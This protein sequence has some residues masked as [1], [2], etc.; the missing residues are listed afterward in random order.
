MPKLWTDDVESH[1][2]AVRSAILDA[3]SALVKEQ[4]LSSLTMSEVA[5]RAGIGRGTLYKYFPDLQA[6]LLAWHER[7][8]AEHLDQ[9]QRIWDQK[10]DV[11]ERLEKVLETFALIAHGHPDGD[12]VTHLHQQKYVIHSQKRLNDFI[13]DLLADAADS[14]GVRTDVP[15]EV[16]AGYCLHALTAASHLPSREAVRR[17]VTVT[18]TGLRQV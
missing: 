5:V 2:R 4:G 11:Y 12:L 13:R 15:P 7:Q 10:G 1:Y 3:T 8:V 16:L 9:L 6:L 18:L 17:L 14:G